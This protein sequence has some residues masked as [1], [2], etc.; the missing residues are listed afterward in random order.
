[1]SSFLNLL[2]LRTIEQEAANLGINLIERA[3][4]S[5]AK[6]VSSQFNKKIVF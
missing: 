4:L 5:I 1:M 2:Q 6:L 3:G